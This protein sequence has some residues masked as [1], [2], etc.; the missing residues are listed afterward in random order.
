[1]VPAP[2]P[3]PSDPYDRREAIRAMAE[4]L[5][6]NDV[7]SETSLGKMEEH[8]SAD[9]RIGRALTTARAFYDAFEAFDINGTTTHEACECSQCRPKRLKA[10]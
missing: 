6:Y 5:F 1:M 7:K 8:K 2:T 9:R 10:R 3:K 4:R